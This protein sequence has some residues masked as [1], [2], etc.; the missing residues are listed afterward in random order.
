MA[1][2]RPGKHSRPNCNH[3]RCHWNRSYIRHIFLQTYIFHLQS[4]RT[5]TRSGIIAINH[6][7]ECVVV[8]WDNNVLMKLLEPVSISH[9]TSCRRQISEK[10][11]VL[12]CIS[13]WWSD[14]FNVQHAIWYFNTQSCCFETFRYIVIRLLSGIE[15]IFCHLFI[16]F[17]IYLQSYFFRDQPIKVFT[18]EMNTKYMI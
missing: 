7:T 5:V 3:F 16:F 10:P 17:S 13:E 11:K 12:R 1:W 4:L 8:G 9:K 14:W 6:M 15:T 18:L 2:H